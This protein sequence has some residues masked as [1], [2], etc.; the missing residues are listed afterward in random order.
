MSADHYAS[1]LGHIFIGT[2]MLLAALWRGPVQMGHFHHR[3]GDPLWPLS[4]LEGLILRV[5]MLATAVVAWWEVW[6][7]YR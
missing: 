4:P 2:L 7:A 5:V 6:S 3:K 1:M